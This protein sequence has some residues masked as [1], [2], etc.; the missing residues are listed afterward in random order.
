MNPVRP[1][2][3]GRLKIAIIGSGIAGNV[4]AHRLR[5]YQDIT[6]FDAADHIGGHTD[7]HRI[8]LD[9]EVH[10][11]DTG[12]IVFNGWTYPTFIALLDE[13]GVASQPSMMS[14]SV[15]H[16]AVGLEYSGSS[17]DGLFAQQ[18]QRDINGA[19]RTFFCGAYRGYG[20]HDDG[21]V[22]ALKAVEHFAGSQ[23]AQRD[24][25]RVA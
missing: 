6:L 15:C 4:A 24:I 12:F 19:R 21:V 11:I 20:F 17:L 10:H 7:T 14:F 13:L 18:R 5:R 9:G 22:S 25:S 1:S 3:G 23:D 2:G 8:E 16:P